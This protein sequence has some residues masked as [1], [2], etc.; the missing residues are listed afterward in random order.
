MTSIMRDPNDPSQS[1]IYKP[2]LPLQNEGGQYGSVPSPTTN[3]SGGLT[4]S[5][6]SYGGMTP[7]TAPLTNPQLPTP[8]TFQ[9]VLGAPP[10]LKEE[11][12]APAQPA[13][14]P[15]PGTTAISANQPRYN[16]NPT[17]NPGPAI[18]PSTNPAA[19]G[20]LS[21]L[22]SEAYRQLDQPTVWDDELAGGIK[23][24]GA[25]GINANFDEADTALDG[26]L[27][28]RGINY[29]T[30][31]GGRIMDLK[32]SRAAALGDLDTSI[33]RERANALAA[34]RS[35]AFGNASRVY[36]DT[37]A[38]GRNDRDELRTE[39]SWNDSTGRADRTEQRGERAYTDGLRREARSDA[40][41]GALYDEQFGR[42][43]D[44]DF[45]DLIG[46][47]FA[48]GSSA[49]GAGVGAIAQA[50]GTY[51]SAAGRYGDSA[52]QADQGLGD[53]GELLARFLG[54]G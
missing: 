12:A 6:P 33:M 50:G 26:E 48:G 19:A 45:Q 52:D 7:P 31:A 8:Q 34:G 39:R 16:V 24:A 21:R 11:P 14:P 38:S 30:I 17:G 13:S 1:E 5:A 43:N 40:M 20:M 51:G 25:R 32:R 9:P 29:S 27:A 41:E 15:P 53:I 35:A 4:L 28:E 49:G 37:D 3:G 42:T 54:A 47:I 44:Q 22:Q 36:G 10:V 18:N 2:S 23:A 46:R